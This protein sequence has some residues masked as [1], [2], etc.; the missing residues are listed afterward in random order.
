MSVREGRFPDPGNYNQWD[1]PAINWMRVQLNNQLNFVNKHNAPEDIKDKN[2]ID[3]Q[4]TMFGYS[5]Q[6]NESDIIYNVMH[7]EVLNEHFSPEWIIDQILM[8]RNV[9]AEYR[10]DN[11]QDKSFT[12]YTTL[13]TGGRGGITQG[14]N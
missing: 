14:V 11:F 10:G 6:L 3:V 12:T 2:R 5:I 7:K 13:I 1:W 9:P 8:A 4:P